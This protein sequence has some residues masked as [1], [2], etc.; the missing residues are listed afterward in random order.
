MGSTDIASSRSL[1]EMVDF[2]KSLS[3]SVLLV[4]SGTIT[5][6]ISSSSRVYGD[7]FDLGIDI[8]ASVLLV[9][10]SGSL[11]CASWMR[12]STSFSI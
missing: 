4:E 10:S 1:S 7:D 9:H 11:C 2:A 8:V 12:W 5:I 3:D 6:F